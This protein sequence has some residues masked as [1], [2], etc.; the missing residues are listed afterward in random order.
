MPKQG[1]HF[2]GQIAFGCD[3]DLQVKL[4]ALSYF[5]GDGGY[6]AYLARNL[7]TRAVEDYISDMDSNDKKRFEQILSSTH[8]EVYTQH[9]QRTERKKKRDAL[10]K[11][12]QDGEHQG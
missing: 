7:M 3:L 9:E 8:V 12:R 2:D 6:Y 1:K 4:V 10:R 11:V 5:V